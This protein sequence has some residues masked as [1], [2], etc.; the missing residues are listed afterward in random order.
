M[1]TLMCSVMAVL[2]CVLYLLNQTALRVFALLWRG[3][4]TSPGCKP[5]THLQWAQAVRCRRASPPIPWCSSLRHISYLERFWIC[6]QIFLWNR[7]SSL[8]QKNR[9]SSQAARPAIIH[10][11]ELESSVNTEVLSFFSFT[12][13]VYGKRS[14][15]GSYDWRHRR[16]YTVRPRYQTGFKAQRGSCILVWLYVRVSSTLGEPSS[17]WCITCLHISDVFPSNVPFHCVC[18]PLVPSKHSTVVHSSEK[19]IRCHIFVL[20][21]F[22]PGFFFFLSESGMLTW[23]NPTAVTHAA[24]TVNPSTPERSLVS[25]WA[26]G[27]ITDC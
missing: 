8:Q 16:G 10:V 14:L 23:E 1:S 6:Q 20:D 26:H 2:S 5:P 18:L 4:L 27:G 13:W 7:K 3:S 9:S 24:L 17:V 25:Q 15:L 21:W 19:L 22:P 11:F 12:M